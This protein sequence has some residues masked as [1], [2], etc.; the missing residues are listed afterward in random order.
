MVEQEP[1]QEK[2][3]QELETEIE[4]LKNE[5]RNKEEEVKRRYKFQ[6]WISKK[7]G[8]I[9]LGWQLKNSIHRLFVELKQG[10]AT[11][12]TLADVATYTL[13]RLTRIGLFAVLATLIPVTFIAIQTYLFSIQNKKIEVQNQEIEVQNQRMIQ[14][15][16]LQEAERRSS[17]VFL[18]SNIQ[19]KIDEEL[20]DPRNKKHT[21]SNQTIGRI[22]AL[23]L[24][25]KPYRY[26]DGDTLIQT[27]ISPERGQLL[28]SL[29]NIGLDSL[30]LLKIIKNGNFSNAEMINAKLDSVNFSGINLSDA[31]LSDANLSD[32][33]LSNA[34][35]SDADLSGAI[36][37][38]TNLSS[39]VL[40]AAEL[41]DADLIGANLSCANLNVADLRA[42]NLSS[43][44]LI[45]ANLS[46]ANL[47]SANL[48]GADLRRTNLRGADL[49]G[50]DLM[51]TN[52]HST[53]LKGAN[54]SGADLRGAD[55]QETDLKGA[56]LESKTE[57]QYVTSHPYVRKFY[58]I[59]EELVDGIILYVLRRK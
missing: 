24:A 31:D 18:F 26:L 22:I 58:K 56:I 45:N 23:S 8:G 5:L 49:R 17:Q 55:L 6:F 10:K 39:A 52:L 12:Q 54:L 21:L 4:R 57:S 59:H 19:D 25:L 16:Y 30:S 46:S 32:A 42:A 47:S 1:N 7:V 14:Q 11:E 13:W 15:T 53:D 48:S 41:N 27:P 51:Y 40:I 33:D 20:K 29:T 43:A 35:L 50:A 44:D 37:R 3:L 38:N 34:D 2:K 36:L 28:L 9:F